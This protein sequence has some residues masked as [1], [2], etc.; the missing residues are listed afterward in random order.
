MFSESHFNR[1]KLICS[2]LFLVHW[3]SLRFKK[4]SVHVF[5][6]RQRTTQIVI[7][8]IW[9][10]SAFLIPVPELHTLYIVLLLGPHCNRL[11]L[12]QLPVG[13]VSCYLSSCVIPSHWFW[14][15]LCDR[16]WPIEWDRRDAVQ[17]LGLGFKGL[18]ASPCT[19]GFQAKCKILPY[20]KGN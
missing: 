15:C 14:V 12:L 4:I 10:N 5:F 19:W 1:R 13:Y 3:G 9:I 17:S 8:F 2:L 16:L 7:I 18:E 6:R 20:C 11:L